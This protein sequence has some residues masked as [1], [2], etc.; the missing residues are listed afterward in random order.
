MKKKKFEKNKYFLPF[1]Y[2]T[3]QCGRYNVF[4]F[5]LFFLTTKS[6]KNHSK[7]L[8]IIG[9]DPFFSLQPQLP[10]TAQNFISVLYILLPNRLCQGLWWPSN[11]RSIW[12]EYLPNVLESALFVYSVRNFKSWLFA[13]FLILLNCEKLEQDLTKLILVIL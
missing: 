1:F 2:A 9:P 3:F 5:F 11:H 12:K 7:K 13:Y 10:K 6:W 8:L 4:K